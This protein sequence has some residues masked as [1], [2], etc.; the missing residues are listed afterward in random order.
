MSVQTQ[1]DRISGAV[2]AALAAL[3]EK[4]V[5][6]P[7]GTKV[8]GLAALIAAIEAGGGG[9]GNISWGTFTLTSDTKDY[10]VTHNLG[11]VPDI[12]LFWM[13]NQ[14]T[15]NLTKNELFFGVNTSES[16]C[17]F[18]GGTWCGAST[19][20]T[21]TTSTSARYMTTSA[22]VT[23]QGGNFMTLYGAPGS[24]NATTVKL[25]TSKENY[26]LCN[27]FDYVWVAIGGLS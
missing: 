11:V 2:S 6:V 22:N 20:M 10:V 13:T 23:R 21:G 8:D 7:A 18:I 1:I 17:D 12:F 24:A 27:G 14:K 9:G 4:G 5:E 3:S 26:F 16:F 25:A 15:S 19:I